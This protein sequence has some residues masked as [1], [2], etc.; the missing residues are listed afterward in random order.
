[1]DNYVRKE[2]GDGQ[3]SYKILPWEP[4]FCVV[5]QY[6]S[7]MSVYSFILSASRVWDPTKGCK[8]SCCSLEVFMN[9]GP[10]NVCM[11]LQDELVIPG[12][13]E[14]TSVLLPITR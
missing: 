1:M 12:S 4:K 9:V 8:A 14:R 5:C 10:R 6:C 7:C 2:N 3:E 11:S 13:N